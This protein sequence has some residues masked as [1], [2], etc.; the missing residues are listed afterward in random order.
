MSKR[1]KKFYLLL[2]LSVLVICAVAFTLYRLYPSEQKEIRT[3]LEKHYVLEDNAVHYFKLANDTTL[4]IDKRIHHI[5]Q[6]MDN[7]IEITNYWYDIEVKE[8][9]D[10]QFSDTDLILL[11]KMIEYS[12]LRLKYC[13]CYRDI[14]ENDKNGNPPSSELNINYISIQHQ[15]EQLLSDIKNLSLEME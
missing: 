3:F 9:Q 12:R 4:D 5:E 13:E 8:N 2:T 7:W 14:L 1:S 11:E 10:P 6:G 15:L